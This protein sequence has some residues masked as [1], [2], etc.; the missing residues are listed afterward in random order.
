VS[1]K[2]HDKKERPKANESNCKI[3]KE[4][5]L[6]PSLVVP[7]PI[8]TYRPRVPYPQTLYALFHSKK[9]KQRDDIL[10]T[11]KQV[12]VNLSFFRRV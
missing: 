10:E 7:N 6:A 3:E 9:D 11:F 8:S 2:E 5:D 12:K 4:N 1:A